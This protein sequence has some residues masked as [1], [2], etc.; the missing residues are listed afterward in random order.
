[1]RSEIDGLVF[2]VASIRQLDEVEHLLRSAFT[3]YV[4][5]L[6]RELAADAYVWLEPA[7]KAGDVFVGKKNGNLIGV[8]ATSLRRHELMIDQ[9]AVHA[10]AQRRGIGSWLLNEVE[11]S[12]RSRGIKALSLDTAEVMDDLL[13]LYDRCGFKEI[14][15]G[16]PSHGKDKHIRVFMRKELQHPLHL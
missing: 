16:L 13:R 2:E 9:I 6:G 11:S 3:P 12:A 5:K 4:R 7:L 8:V 1:M 14:R 15:R 10:E